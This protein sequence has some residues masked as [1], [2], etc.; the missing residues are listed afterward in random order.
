MFCLPEPNYPNSR[1][2]GV[3]RVAAPR[4]LG[5]LGPMK[6]CTVMVKVPPGPWGQ[7][8]R[9][10]SGEKEWRPRQTEGG[11]RCPAEGIAGPGVSGRTLRPKLVGSGMWGQKA[12][13]PGPAACLPQPKYQLAEEK[14]G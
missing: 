8:R 2:D 7:G 12:A 6:K 5:G 10:L 14:E 11:K 1:G 13:T 9:K 3:W 4:G